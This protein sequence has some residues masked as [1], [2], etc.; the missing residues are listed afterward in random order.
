VIRPQPKMLTPCLYNQS[1]A[2]SR[3]NINYCINRLISMNYY[4][5]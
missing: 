4:D 2:T 3:P 5:S 1:N